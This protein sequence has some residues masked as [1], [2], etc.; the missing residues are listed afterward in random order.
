ML[1]MHLHQKSEALNE[2]LR[3]LQMVISSLIRPDMFLLSQS[4]CEEICDVVDGNNVTGVSNDVTCCSRVCQV[5][6]LVTVPYLCV[7]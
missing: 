3:P 6:Q 4:V 5:M 7:K 2:L 1:S